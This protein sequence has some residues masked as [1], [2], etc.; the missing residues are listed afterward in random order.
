MRSAVAAAIAAGGA[1]AQRRSWPLSCVDDADGQLAFLGPAYCCRGCQYELASGSGCQQTLN[2]RPLSS[3]CPQSCGACVPSPPPPLGAAAAPPPPPPPLAPCADDPLWQDAVGWRCADFAAQRRACDGAGKDASCW[4]AVCDASQGAATR[5]A[6]TCGG[7]A[8]RLPPP[9]PPPPPPPQPAP[10]PPP[11]APRAASDSDG[12]EVALWFFLAAAV[13]CLCAAAAAV[14]VWCR[15]P[16]GGRAAGGAPQGV[17]EAQ[18]LGLASG[19]AARQQP[20]VD[21]G[22]SE[23]AGAAAASAP[24]PG[25]QVEANWNGEWL[26][27]TVLSEAAGVYSVTWDEDAS[28]THGMAAEDVR[29]RPAAAGG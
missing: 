3:I 1:A 9:P 15:G 24:R 23:P 8:A 14:L 19:T 2:G 7:C 13:C 20:A 26:P 12:D 28:Q 27:A 6:L 10:P 5:C 17:E 21:P 4:R 16:A 29:P 18:P 11:A 25:D 22:H